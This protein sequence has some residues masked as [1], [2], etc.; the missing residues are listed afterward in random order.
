MKSI[1]LPLPPW[2]FDI[3]GFA[4]GCKVDESFAFNAV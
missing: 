3:A 2:T 4:C 1:I